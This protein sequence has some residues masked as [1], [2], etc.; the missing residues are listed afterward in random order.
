MNAKIITLI[1]RR[2]DTGS[3]SWL[4]P[5]EHI[6]AERILMPALTLTS[7][8]LQMLQGSLAR[9]DFIGIRAFTFAMSFESAEFEKIEDN[10]DIE[11]ILAAQGGDFTWRPEMK[12]LVIIK[13]KDVYKSRKLSKVLLESLRQN[14]ELFESSVRRLSDGA[15]VHHCKRS[16]PH[17]AELLR[18]G[19][20]DVEQV[21]KMTGINGLFI[22][23][24]LELIYS[25]RRLITERDGAAVASA[26]KL[27]FTH[28]EVF[29]LTGIMPKRRG[30]KK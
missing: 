25:Q 5:C 26:L 29:A 3:V 21:K 22:H 14:G 11:L 6:D 4:N 2:D 20:Y 9:Q 23:T 1:M 16:L 12:E 24:V 7:Q 15:L 13:G 17:A 30:K 19:L 8:D 10:S 18:R 28:E 27:G